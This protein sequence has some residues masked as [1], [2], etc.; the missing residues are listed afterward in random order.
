MNSYVILLNPFLLIL[1]YFKI[2]NYSGA[3]LDDARQALTC[4]YKVSYF[5][6]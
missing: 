1:L 3:L 2:E 6:L 5:S 4:G